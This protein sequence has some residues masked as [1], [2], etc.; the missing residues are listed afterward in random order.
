[1]IERVQATP[2]A[3]ALV[4][5]LR[6]EHGAIYFY[7]SHGCCEGSMPMCFAPGDMPLTADDRMLGHINGVP[8]H[9]SSSQGEYL[10]GLEVT[11]DLAPCSG[12]SFSLE[13]GS[14]Q[15]FVVKLRLWTD[16][17]QHQLALQ[18]RPLPSVGAA[19]ELNKARQP[20][21]ATASTTV[22]GS[23]R[24]PAGC[25]NPASVS[26]SRSRKPPH[27]TLC[28]LGAAP[29]AATWRRCVQLPAGSAASA[30]AS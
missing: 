13:D 11:L 26:T 1:M 28:S 30:A 15:H 4:E 16:E 27:V 5:R 20:S 12:G 2:A 14:G 8:F 23:L 21:V 7:Q 18:P 6:A 9:A 19:A 29:D 3:Q 22:V 10:C 24:G 17:E 25:P